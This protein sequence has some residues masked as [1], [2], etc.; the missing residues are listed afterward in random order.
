[1]MNV[2]EL[3]QLAIDALENIKG[4]NLVTLDVR[5]QTDIADVMI[6]AT[7]QSARQVKALAANVIEQAKQADAPPLSVEGED[8]GA[9]VLVDLGDVL[10][11]VMLEEVRD[12][13]DLESLWSLSPSDSTVSS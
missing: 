3:T 12:L 10:V 9:W 13:Y 5:G 11:H 8:E 1:M 4:Q 6:V 2:D 7:G